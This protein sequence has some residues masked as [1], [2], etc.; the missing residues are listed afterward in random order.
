MSLTQGLENTRLA[1]AGY[2]Q[3]PGGPLCGN[4][5]YFVGKGSRCTHPEIQA[6]VDAVNGCCNLWESADDQ[7]RVWGDGGRDND[8][9]Q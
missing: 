5:E 6:K 3:Y 9:P 7:G 4:C 1:K 8:E 2:V